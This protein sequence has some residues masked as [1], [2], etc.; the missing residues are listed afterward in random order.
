MSDTPPLPL[1]E[2]SSSPQEES[3]PIGN[4]RCPDGLQADPRSTAGAGVRLGQEDVAALL[5]F[6]Q[7]LQQW[8]QDQKI[9]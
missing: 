2:R 1:P 3:N 5:A 9:V 4:E 7:L 8:D 6:F